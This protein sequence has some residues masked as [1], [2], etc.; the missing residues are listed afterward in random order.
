MRFKLPILYSMRVMIV[1]GSYEMS[2]QYLEVSIKDH[3]ARCTMSNPPTHTMVAQEAHE[4]YLFLDEVD[5]DPGV[6]V[7][8]FTGGGEG[9][10]IRHY[11]VG[12]LVAA[13]DTVRSGA[14]SAQK[15]KIF[16]LRDVILKMESMD[17]IT[18]A[19]ING[20]T[21]G[22]GLE[23][24]LGCDFRLQKA[25]EYLLGLPETGV[26]I[27]PG[28]GGTQRLARLLGTAKALDLILLGQVYGPEK[29]L[30]LGV[31]SRVF[32]ASTFEEDVGG[33]VS[34][35]AKRAPRALANAKRAIREGVE[36][37]LQPARDHLLLYL[38][39]TKPS[40]NRAR[41]SPS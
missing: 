2:Y 13:S 30:D 41:N 15:E 8:V 21:M 22:G 27:L 18:V 26:G 6:R 25:G 35:I 39:Y 33:F 29:A 37:S 28:G 24:A 3:V 36:M 20:S 17:A 12:E 7:V 31:V 34:M 16:G 5:S 9:V 19:A 10:F 23:F 32:P 4:L 40:K 11:E 1:G 14:A 38:D